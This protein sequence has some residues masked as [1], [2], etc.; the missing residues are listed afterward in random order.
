MRLL[1]KQKGL[2][3]SVLAEALGVKRAVIGAYEEGRAEP[4]LAT[5]Q[6]MAH[7]FGVTADALLGAT[8]VIPGVATDV[9]GASLRVLPIAVDAATQR[10]R[11]TVVPVKAAA[12]YLQGYGDAG[13]IG[14]LP[15]FNLPLPDLPAD[16]TYRVFQVE[17]DSMLPI[18]AGTYL[19]AEYIE[20]WEQVRNGTACVVLTRDEGIVFKR[21][22]NLLATAGKLR[23]VSDNSHYAPYTV[24]AGQV[25]E[26]WRVTGHIALGAPP[27]PE[28]AQADLQ[29]LARSVAHLQEE[30]NTLK[31]LA[32]RKR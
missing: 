3:Q 20:N 12:G 6:L 19:I 4:R 18:V 28:W 9:R 21:V 15:S 24:D 31:Q 22:D 26:L 8:E 25:L 2:T 27:A 7:Y 11:I 30:V 1:R 14:S 5:L 13:Y 29:S 10:E 17:G 23:L 16:R 32:G